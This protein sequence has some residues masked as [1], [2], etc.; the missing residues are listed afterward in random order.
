MPLISIFWSL[1]FSSYSICVFIPLCF[2]EKGSVSHRYDRMENN[3]NVF[4]F[5]LKHLSY[6]FYTVTT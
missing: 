6:R 1:N 3:E 4:D 2:H 5:I